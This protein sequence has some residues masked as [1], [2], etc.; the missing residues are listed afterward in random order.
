M[1]THGFESNHSAGRDGAAANE[2]Q[3]RSPDDSPVDLRI[4]HHGYLGSRPPQADAL[5]YLGSLLSVATG[6]EPRS[7][8]AIGYLRTL[9][10]SF[11]VGGFDALAASPATAA[12]VGSTPDLLRRLGAG[13]AWLAD[14][15]FVLCLGGHASAAAHRGICA[16][17]CGAGLSQDDTA[18]F[19]SLIAALAAENDVTKV[20]ACIHSLSRYDGGAWKAIVDYRGLSFHEALRGLR[21]SLASTAT[22]Q[23]AVHLSLDMTSERWKVIDCMSGIPD[24][25]I[26][27]RVAVAANRQLRLSKFDAFKQKV[28]AFVTRDAAMLDEA[29]RITRAF[30]LHAKTPHEPRPAAVADRDVDYRNQDWIDHMDAAYDALQATLD[31]YDQAVAEAL[32]KITSIADGRW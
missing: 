18:K 4:T 13:W 7:E 12:P 23:D 15:T 3:T 29:R 20:L 24:E 27:V 11:G 25:G 22:L 31:D 30:G 9:A 21:S 5:G 26:A 1:G 28:E 32:D 10:L 19:A 2:T 6:V 8:H 16:V 17:A 14:A